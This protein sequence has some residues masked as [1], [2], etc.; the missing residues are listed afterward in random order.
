MVEFGT[1]GYTFENG[2]LEGLRYIT[3]TVVLFSIQYTLLNKIIMNS[4]EIYRLNLI[5]FFVCT[6]WAL[7]GILI[8]VILLLLGAGSG[9]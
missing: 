6:E 1:S 3:Q 4:E 2:D 7:L 9:K 5:Y 8:P